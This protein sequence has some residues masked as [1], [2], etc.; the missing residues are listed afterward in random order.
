VDTLPTGPIQGV[1]T[2][3]QSSREFSELSSQSSSHE[4]MEVVEQTESYPQTAVPA[5]PVETS[6]ANPLVSEM[7]YFR[8]LIWKHVNTEVFPL[9]PESHSLSQPK[10]M[11]FGALAPPRPEYPRLSSKALAALPPSPSVIDCCKLLSNTV[12]DSTTG[13]VGHR[14]TSITTLDSCGPGAWTTAGRLFTP[15]LPAV[16][17]YEPDYYKLDTLSCGRDISASILR[18]E[19]QIGSSLLLPIRN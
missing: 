2:S 4:D 10:F 8:A 17:K 5:Q 7:A 3:L 9:P 11:I 12:S 14:R 13:S 1:A 16:D 18:D 6:T 15:S 19:R